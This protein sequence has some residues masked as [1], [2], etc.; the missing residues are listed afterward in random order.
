MGCGTSKTSNAK[1][2]IEYLEVV[3]KL[4]DKTQNFYFYHRKWTIGKNAA[5]KNKNY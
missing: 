1:D 3:I 4:I 5:E 2:Y